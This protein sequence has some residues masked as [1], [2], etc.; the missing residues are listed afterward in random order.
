MKSVLGEDTDIFRDGSV[1]SLSIRDGDIHI[2][3]TLHADSDTSAVGP[4]TGKNTQTT[5]SPMGPEPR[6]LEI[7]EEAEEE[8]EDDIAKRTHA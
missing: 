1:V 5:Y 7:L 6:T 4:E 2:S 3:Y 8:A